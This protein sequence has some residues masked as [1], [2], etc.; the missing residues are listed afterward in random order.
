VGGQV[1]NLKTQNPKLLFWQDCVPAV[2]SKSNS[3]VNIYYYAESEKWW[4]EK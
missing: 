4:A 1:Q 2:E 3:Y